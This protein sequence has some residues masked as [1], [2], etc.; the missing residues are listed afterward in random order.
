V[1]VRPLARPLED[2]AMAVAAVIVAPRVDQ[3]Q[4]KARAPEDSQTPADAKMPA[5]PQEFLETNGLL[6]WMDSEEGRHYLL[7]VCMVRRRAAA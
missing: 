5:S 2:T 3:T 6:G 4:R 7:Y 1:L